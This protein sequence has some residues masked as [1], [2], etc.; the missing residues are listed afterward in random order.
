[1]HARRRPWK[2]SS[3]IVRRNFTYDIRHERHE[4][5]RKSFD[6][7]SSHMHIF[8][9][10]IKKAYAYFSWHKLKRAKAFLLIYHFPFHWHP[11]DSFFSQL[12]YGFIYISDCVIMLG[13]KKRNRK[14][15]EK[16]IAFHFISE[17]EIIKIGNL[18]LVLGDLV[19]SSKL[20]GFNLQAIQGCERKS[21]KKLCILI[22]SGTKKMEYKTR[23]WHEKCFCCCVCKTPIGT[24]SFIPREQDIYCAGCYED[25]FATRCVKCKKVSVN[26]WPSVIWFYCLDK[27]RRV[28]FPIKMDEVVAFLELICQLLCGISW[29]KWKCLA[30]WMFWTFKKVCVKFAAKISEIPIVADNKIPSLDNLSSR[31]K[32]TSISIILSLIGHNNWRCYLQKRPVPQ[33]MLRMYSLRDTIGRTTLHKSRR[34]AILCWLLR[35]IVCKALYCMHQAYYW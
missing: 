35:W 12:D 18:L 4:K 2:K 25:K 33:G 5:C 1:M 9:L 32:S 15:R 14:K 26:I 31:Q 19:S 8:I 11:L 34:K 10:S 16:F 3:K 27:C 13:R 6:Q 30:F 23:Q 22:F 24:K 21:N 29:N 17:G 7:I 28:H 20:G